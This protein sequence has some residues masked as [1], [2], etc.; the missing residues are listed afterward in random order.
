M[1]IISKFRDYYDPIQ[2]MGIDIQNTYV[3]KREVIQVNKDKYPRMFSFNSG[4]FYAVEAIR[5]GFCGKFYSIIKTTVSTNDYLKPDVRFFHD[6]KTFKV[7]YEKIHTGRYLYLRGYKE[8]FEFN[9]SK[10]SKL[11]FEHNT[12]LLAFV[13]DRMEGGYILIKNPRLMDYKFQRHVDPYTT[14]QE[15][16]MYRSGVIG[17]M[18]ADTVNIS[19]EDMKKK[20]G[21]GHKYAFKKEP[22]R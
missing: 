10:Y 3:R 12:P 8:F 13:Y 4:T 6:F 19:D 16:A 9:M 22:S 7:Y 2:G 15:I 14:F 5:L 20:K 11:F 17:C 21:F 18:G 1:R